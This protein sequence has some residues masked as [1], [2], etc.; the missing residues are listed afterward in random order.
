M[1]LEVLY[2]H[3]R[4]K[5]AATTTSSYSP[6]WSDTLLASSNRHRMEVVVVC[7]TRSAFPL[8]YEE[9]IRDVSCAITFS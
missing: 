4:K 7:C 2:M 5:F 8:D 9:N 3:L 6:L 1:F